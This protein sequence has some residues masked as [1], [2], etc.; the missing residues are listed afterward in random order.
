MDR[1]EQEERTIAPGADWQPAGDYEDIR[2]ETA[3]GHR[4]DHDRPPRGAQR[5]PARRR[6]SSSRD[7]LERA[8]EDTAVGVIVLTGEGP[9]AFCSGG[10]QRVRGDSGYVT[11]RR[12][13][14]GVGRFHV[15]DLHVQIRRLPKPVVA[16]VAG[17]AIGGGHVLHIVCDLTIAADNARFGQTGPEGR[18]LRRRLRRR[19]ARAPRSGRRRPRRSGSSAAST[20]RRRRSTWGSSTPSCRSSSSRTETVQWCREMLELSPFSL[21]LLKASFNAAEDGLGRASSSSPTTRTSSSTVARRRRRAATPTARSAGPTSASSR[22]PP[23]SAAPRCGLVAARP[24]TLPAAIAPVLVGTA[25]AISEDEFRAAAVRRRAGR[26]HLHP[27]RH[28]PRQRLLR[29]PPRRRHR[30]PPRPGARDRRRADAAAARCSSAPTWRSGSRSPAGAYLT[31]SPGWELLVV[32]VASIAA[33][34]LYTGGPRPY[35]YAGLGELFV[36]LFFGVVAVVGSYYVQTEELPWEAF[37]LSVPVGLLAAAILVVNNVRDID[38]DRRAGKR[39]LAVKLGR[40]RARVLFAAMLVRRLPRAASRS[41]LAGGL[42]L[43][44][45]CC[46]WRRA[47]ARAAALAHGVDADRRPVAQRRAGRHRPAARRSSR[48]CSRRASCCREALAAAAV[49]PAARA[50]RDRR[51]A[52]WPSASSW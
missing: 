39:T 46:R 38:T 9:L 45:R 52:S 16:M 49:D 20:T 28:E 25:L 5:V 48:C 13:A 6:S 33:G 29:R 24:R 19:P 36:F 44:G 35:G 27:D 37:A 34:V 8:R 3:D 47:A 26:Q 42:T 32:G 30:G 11:E 23:V 7:A 43:V 31:A 12:G 10:D 15:T 41:P 14:G 50:V 1:C 22:K 4:Q 17:Y 40:E 2:Y 18:L 51:R 21:R